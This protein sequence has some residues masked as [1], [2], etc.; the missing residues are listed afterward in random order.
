MDLD[1]TASDHH[2]TDNS[3]NKYG[4]THFRLEKEPG[5]GGFRCSLLLELVGL[6]DARPVEL[7]KEVPLVPSPRPNPNP[8]PSPNPRPS[9]RP[10]PSPNAN[11]SPNP[12]PDPNPNPNPR[13]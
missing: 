13:P 9:P 6:C 12:N 8:N 11:P 2:F 10:S 7:L 3:S 4:H 5:H 1:F